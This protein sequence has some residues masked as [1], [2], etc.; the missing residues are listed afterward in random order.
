MEYFGGTGRRSRSGQERSNWLKRGDGDGLLGVC[1][2]GIGGGETSSR[3]YSGG[4]GGE[5]EAGSGQ[6]GGAQNIAACYTPHTRRFACSCSIE[7]G[8]R[9]SGTTVMRA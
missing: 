7:V 1:C 6:T 4:A 3:T 5:G 9:L 8:C 2:S